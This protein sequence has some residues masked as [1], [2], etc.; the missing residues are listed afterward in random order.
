MSR[1]LQHIRGTT[2]EIETLA[3]LAAELGYDT[4]RK[5]PHIGD[6]VTTGG[7]RLAK[8]NTGEILVPAQLTADTDDYN[9]AGMKH[10]ATLI[11][12]TDAARDITGLV[13]TTVTD[14]VDGREITIYNG[15]GF[16]ARLVDQ[17]ASSAAA[18]R[19]DFGGQD[20]QLAPKRSVT[21]R[22]RTSGG[23]DRWELVAQTIGAGV[24]AGAVIAMTLAASSQG[25]SLINGVIATSVAA[26]AL[27]IAIKTLA[28][29]DPSTL[30]P[31]LVKV[32]D[33]TLANGG[34]T[35]HALTAATSL[36]VSSGSSLGVSGSATAFRLWLVAFNDAGTLRL[37]I[38][39]CL[40]GAAEL[41]LLKTD[42]LASATAEGGAGGADSSG[43]FYTGAAVASKPF[44]VLGYLDYPAGLAAAG[45]WS[46]NPTTVQPFH[47][48][49]K[50]PA[51]ELLDPSNDRIYL[52][53][54]ASG[55][56]DGRRFVRDDR[57]LAYPLKAQAAGTY[58]LTDWN[59]ALTPGVYDGQG[60]ANAPKGN[61]ADW[62]YVEVM[63]HSNYGGGNVYVAQIAT[64][65]TTHGRWVRSNLNGTWGA[66]RRLD[67]RVLLNTIAVPSGTSAINDTTSLLQDFDHFE[68]VVNGLISTVNNQKYYV[69]YQVGGTFQTTGY[70]AGTWR[71]NSGGSGGDTKTDGIPI[72]FSFSSTTLP[73]SAI[74]RI[75]NPKS[76]TCH[77]LCTSQS[78]DTPSS[79]GIVGSGTY[80]SSTGA[81]TGF[82][83]IP[84]LGGTMSGE[85]VQVYGLI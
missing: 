31:V 29:N 36:V 73:F 42:A 82:Q 3:P 20:M 60:L 32:R 18:N 72:N 39:N 34:F 40:L 35:V 22:Y 70:S 37:G 26:G 76:T 77:K 49:I 15:G 24:G 55:T 10:A 14:T 84:A 5:E 30:D 59:N 44:A 71:Y 27:T 54:V 28:G 52:S 68:V 62:F 12:S 23:L 38:V 17:S 79:N 53:R 75:G 2:A 80:S 19:F 45:A 8:K 46:I 63:Q 78:W 11:I 7:V 4:T 58:S 1:R 50:L 64:G 47:A 6:G 25:Y 66:W 57:T 67:S 33:A 9:P 51:A 83:I 48:G 61:T 81:V 16:M 69:R 74:F 43:V 56:P 13:P 85:S 41:P 65:L 21:L